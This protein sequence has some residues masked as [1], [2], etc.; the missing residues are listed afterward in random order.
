FA[1]Q[2]QVAIPAD[3]LPSWD[4]SKPLKIVVNPISRYLPG[5]YVKPTSNSA[6]GTSPKA[7]EKA[8]VAE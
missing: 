6:A 1:K 3:Q 7:I 2:E 4:R 5:Q 8:Q